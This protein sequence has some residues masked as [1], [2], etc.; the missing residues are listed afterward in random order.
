[1]KLYAGTTEQF[2]ADAQMHRIA[3]KLRAEYTAQIGHRPSPNEVASWQNSLMALSMLVDQ[4]A[5]NDHGIILEYQLGNTS[6]RLDA[7]LTGH[8]ATSAEN[9]VVVELKQ[10]SDGSIGPSTADNCVE[11]YVGKQVRRVLH[12]SVQVGGY[13]Q[14]LLDNHSVFYETDA[15]ALTAVSYLHNL[16]FDADGELWADRHAEAL[17]RNPLYTGDQ[18]TEL[19]EFLNHHL[20]AGEGNG[21]MARVLESTYRPSRKLL[22]H[23]AAM[24][25]ANSEFVLLDEQRVAFESVLAAARDGY[26]DAKKSVVLVQGGPGTGKSIIAL[27]LVGELAKRGFNAMHATGSKAF[28]ENM[29]RVVGA[30][31]GQSQFN[32][33]NQFGNADAN[34][35]DVLILDEAHRLRETSASRFTPK[36]KRTDLPQVDE[37]IQ[38]AKTTVFFIDDFQT[39][40]PNEVGSTQRILE[41]A[42]RNGADVSTFELETQF[43]LAGSKA[44]LQWVDGMLGLAETINP[45]WDADRETFD[46]RIVDSVEQLDALIRSKADE[47]HSARMTAGFC[48]PWSNPNPDGTLAPDVKVGPW[49]MPWNARPDAGRLAPGIPPSNFWASD[50][51]GLN[52]V[53]CVY[54]AQGFEFDY[55][56][57]IW[58]R[59]LRWDP[60]TNDWIGDP[61]HSYDRPVKSAPRDRFTD[62]VKRTYRVL[63]TRGLMGC[64]LHFEDEGTRDNVL[65]RIEVPIH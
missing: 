22:E 65:T 29:R 25:K 33:F 27:H 24:I 38:A 18:S 19:A 51:N 8:A 41:A 11:L 15:V 3:E 42:E 55:V 64:Y 37:L 12:P 21:V 56:G 14:W 32:Y 20:S 1:M 23:V 9:A 16:Q 47:G 40:R 61:S 58:G 49:E 10:W 36:E 57:V 4:A 39:V 62:L 5:L 45:T 46:F 44:F 28:T 30:R 34:D 35:V 50:P 63:L 26:H 59:D 13:Q 2:R 43:R 48:W 52:Q 53:G 60:A 31:A 6:R 7:M 54:T 17:H